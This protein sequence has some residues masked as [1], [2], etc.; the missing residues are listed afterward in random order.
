MHARDDMVNMPPLVYSTP[1]RASTV[2]LF[3]M[4][5]VETTQQT[6]DFFLALRCHCVW[7]G[8]ANELVVGT[9]KLRDEHAAWSD[10]FEH[11]RE[12]FGE[13]LR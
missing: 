12:H 8:V 1:N 2:H 5:N 3:A 11:A 4:K 7:R 6:A 13:T 10:S 9:E